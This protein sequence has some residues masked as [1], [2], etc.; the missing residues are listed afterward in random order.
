VVGYNVEYLAHAMELEHLAQP[1][2]VLGSAQL[3]IKSL[4]VRCI[5]AMRAARPSL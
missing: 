4:M 3:G 5:I 2:V 1:L